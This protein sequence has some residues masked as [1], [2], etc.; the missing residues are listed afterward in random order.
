M[1]A[2]NTLIVGSGA[3]ARNAAV[4][5]ARLGVQEVAIVTDGWNRG[6]SFNAG[7]DKQTYY[8]LSLAGRAVD[9]P[10]CLAE[11]L[12]AGGCMHGDIALC[13]A[14]HS[15]QAFLHLVQLGVPFPQDR[16]GGFVGYQTDHDERARA[17]S[18]GPL[19]SQQMCDCLGQAL[20]ST[21][22]QIFDQHQVVRV[23]TSDEHTNRR[24]CGAIALD[25]NSHTLV[26]F[27]AVN[28]I[29]ATGGPGGMYAA[30]VYP[31]SQV[32]ATGLGLAIGATAHNLTESQFGLASIGFRWN[33]SGSY[34]QVIPRFFSTAQD[35]NDESDF[36]TKH[37][38]DPQALAGAIF[39]KGYQWPLDCEKVRGGSSLIDVLVFRETTRRGRRVWLDFTRNVSGLEDFS[40]DSLDDEAAGYLRRCKATQATPIERLSAMN[41]PAVDLFRDHGIDLASQPLEIAVC[42]QH[43]NGGLRGNIW[44][45]S[46]VEHLFPIGEVNGTHGV[47][48]PGGAALN[49]GQVGGLRAAMFIARR[50][51][52]APPDVEKFTNTVAEQTQQAL[53]LHER[54]LSVDKRTITPETAIAEIQ[55][56]MS[57]HAGA[58]RDPGSIDKA[59]AD[60]WHQFKSLQDSLCAHEHQ[61]LVFAY[62]AMDLGLTHA[63]YLEAL[64]V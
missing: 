46:N 47:R 13:E 12:F 62:Q 23:L 30:S 43:N 59:V 52:E 9:S 58:V 28:I 34:Q 10:R 15:A 41:Q 19:T 29:L 16:H 60:A 53:D 4:Q 17:T 2:V 8:K 3:A 44:W 45:E 37:F 51:T 22:V 36:L 64:Q 5:L 49:A 32:G 24:V 27:N 1:F 42:A 54:L 57:T 55:H 21:E 33:V 26:L 61:D 14:Q 40:V 35:G 11:D 39:R 48:R 63:V 25:L 7:S 56:R 38:S 50:Y 18:A 31:G 20:E 6:T